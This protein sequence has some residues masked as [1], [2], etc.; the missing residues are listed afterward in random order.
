MSTNIKLMP[1]GDEKQRFTRWLLVVLLLTILL[2]VTLFLFYPPQSYPDTAAY[3]RLAESVRA[4]FKQFDGTRGPGYPA[5]LALFGPVRVVYVV[6]LFLGCLITLMW[7]LVGWGVSHKAWFAGLL[8]LGYSLNPNQFFFEAALLTE[9]V[10]T[11]FLTLG[12]LGAFLWLWNARWRKVWV[13]LATGLAT[14]LAVL[15]RPLFQY[16]PVLLI[17]FLGFSFKEKKLRADWK[18]ILTITLVSVL[19][20]GGWMAW[21]R[22]HYHVFS[23]TTLMGYHLTQHTGY[24]FEQVPDQY[25]QIR[26]IYIQFRDAQIAEYGIQ[27][28][29]IWQAIP[30][31]LDAT[32]YNFYELS[33]VMQSISIQ[34][35]LANPVRF[36]LSIIPDWWYFWRVPVLFTPAAVVSGGLAGLLDAL[37]LG[38]R[39]VLFGANLVFI[40]TSLA[41]LV[42]KKWRTQWALSAFHWLVAGYVWGASAVSSILEQGNNPRYLVP[43]QTA[44]V[45]WSL[46]V[47][48]QTWQVWWTR[49]GERKLGEQG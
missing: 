21:I 46:W 44:V 5:F 24:L 6:Q 37:I 25:A 10:S 33:R 16:L 28:N 48:W 45:F 38:V 23:T 4:G 18:A 3:Q 26:D 22:A 19:V 11:F 41:G 7:F 31:I 12:L 40:L 30:A 20:V 43:L 47:L 14:A 15:T 32:D 29:A 2:R 17:I 8:A 27:G 9:T 39:M 34:L 42:V 35:I 36:V 13:G 1:E 49:R